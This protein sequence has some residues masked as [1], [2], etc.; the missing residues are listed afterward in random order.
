MLIK[1]VMRFPIRS[2]EEKE[3]EKAEMKRENPTCYNNIQR[4]Q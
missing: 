2:E 3:K 4:S 1:S